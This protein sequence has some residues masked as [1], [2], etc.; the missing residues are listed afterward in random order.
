MPIENVWTDVCR[1]LNEAS[2]TVNSTESLFEEVQHK[3]A[4]LICDKQ[5]L[6]QLVRQVKSNLK[7]VVEAKGNWI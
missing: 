1:E 2:V 4:D 5:Y 3:W 7:L 6:V